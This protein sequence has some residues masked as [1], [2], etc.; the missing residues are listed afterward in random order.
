V[1]GARGV[2]RFTAALAVLAVLATL[3]LVVLGRR[4]RSDDLPQA[5]PASGGELAESASQQAPSPTLSPTSAPS[6]AP[7]AGRSSFVV[8]W[9]PLPPASPPPDQP[10]VAPPPRATEAPQPCVEYTWGVSDSPAV[11]GQVLVEIRVRNRC[12]R[13]LQPLEVMFRAEGFRSG[14]SIYSAQGNLLEKIYPNSVRTVMVALPGST[15]FFDHV[16]VV[17]INPPLR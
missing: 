4:Q 10:A 14:D 7:A 12:G 13:V 5:G 9:V 3:L 15:S 8:P 1:S 16:E 11:L 17:P 6:P 2:Q